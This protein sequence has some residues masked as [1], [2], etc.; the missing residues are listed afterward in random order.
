MK[1]GSLVYLAE[2]VKSCVAIPV[3]AIGRLDDPE[4]A[5]RVLLQRQADFIGIGR[6]LIADPDWPKKVENGRLATIRKCLACN[7]C[8]VAVRTPRPIR[9]SVNAASGRES[10]YDTIEPVRV[11]KRV[12]IAGGGPAGMEAARVAAIKGHDVTLFEV[13]PKLGG[14]VRLVSIPPGKAIFSTL[15]NYYEA[16]LKRLGVKLRL[17]TKA[18]AET[19]LREAPDT[20]IVA[21]GGVPL[22]PDMRGKVSPMVILAQDVLSGKKKTG[23]QV[24]IVGGGF[25]GCEVANY[26]A[27]KGKTI[28][29][30]ELLDKLASDMEASIRLILLAQLNDRQVKML[31]STTLESVTDEGV[32]LCHKDGQCSA[33]RADTVVIACGF[34]RTDGLF[35]ELKGKVAEL[36]VI[37]D[38]KQ[39]RRII[40]AVS[41]G[42]VTAFG[43]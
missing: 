8:S 34:K 33:L 37:G 30:I 36:H 29:I 5:E 23:K 32:L 31:T 39:P 42:F 43:I 27:D 15:V 19:I 26:L 25:I 40:D 9:C 11:Q 38:A 13:F 7:E 10:Q 17:G 21:T 16:E 18:T 41:E 28:T 3:T 35:E 4:L 12:V 24:V 2:A 6:G 20:V 1:P 22:I 14:L